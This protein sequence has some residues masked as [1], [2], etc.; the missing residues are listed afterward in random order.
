MRENVL[1]QSEYKILNFGKWILLVLALGIIVMVNIMANIK[2]IQLVELIS[3]D[4]GFSILFMIGMINA[5]CFFQLNSVLKD[6]KSNIKIEQ[7]IFYLIVILIVQASIFNYCLAGIIVYS[8]YK[9]IDWK[10]FSLKIAWKDLK[11]KKLQRYI[12]ANSTFFITL[13]G[14]LYTTIFSIVR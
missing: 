7:N 13:I 5:L 6:F 12:Y 3:T 8:L 2:G 4:I 14:T 11:S 9:Y 1:K 10:K